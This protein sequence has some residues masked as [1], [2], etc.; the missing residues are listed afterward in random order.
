MTKKILILLLTIITASSLILPGC[1]KIGPATETTVE[2][3][4]TAVEAKETTEETSEEKISQE[5]TKPQA[6]K[7]EVTFTTEDG[8][9]INGNIFGSGNRWVIL[10]HMFPT[11]QTSWFDFAQYLAD[12]GYIVLTYD[13]RGY[14]KSGGNQ[15]IPNIDKDLEA[16]LVFVRQHD[17]EKVFL[18]GASMGGTVS[19][20]V[21]SRQ[22][23]DGVIS[24]SSPAK[25]MSLSA[26]NVIK[27][28]NTPKL[29][30][31]SR[32]DVE[33]AANARAL[34]QASSEPKSLSILDG[35]AHGTYIF[36]DEPDNAEILK[37]IV[38]DFLNG[39]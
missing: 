18:M 9:D 6:Q 1:G 16:A 4:E 20:I 22:P 5:E 28:I 24:F 34:Y 13:F 31:A 36:D 25:M 8:I 23:V 30:I 37:Q 11:D 2:A 35:G 32:G 15:D 26:I 33:E 19:L 39:N 10:S 38:L 27:N 17:A 3:T 12:N 29:F 7:V 21:A 14:G